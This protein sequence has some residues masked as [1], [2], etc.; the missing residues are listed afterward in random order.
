[1]SWIA[2]GTVLPDLPLRPYLLAPATADAMARRAA[3]EGF[4]VT[5]AVLPEEPDEQALLRAVGTALEFP[6]Y[7]GENWDAFNECLGD[8]E[9]RGLFRV[10]VLRGFDRYRRAGL[11]GFVR[12]VHL[13]ESS[14]EAVAQ[15]YGARGGLAFVYVG[16]EFGR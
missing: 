2:L 16:E 11:H 4:T 5:E 12:A 8:T 1:M 3:E 9:L 6:S 14:S 7:Y 10:V 13:L 15:E